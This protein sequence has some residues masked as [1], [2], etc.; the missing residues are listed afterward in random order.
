MRILIISGL[1]LLL[2]STANADPLPAWRDGSTKNA[3][4]TWLEDVTSLGG[5]DF[6][7]AADRIA[8]FDNDG[9]SWCERPGYG[10]TDFQISLARSL[11]AAGQ[12]DD[13][14]M[15][16]KAWFANDRSALRKYGYG[17]AYQEMNAAFAGMPLLAYRDSARTWLAPCSTAHR[18]PSK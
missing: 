6:I 16:F 7:P 3:I 14:A 18:R 9:T 5:P 15:P 12:I 10:P 13:T 11:A 2:T 17:K 1:L 8:V 4:V